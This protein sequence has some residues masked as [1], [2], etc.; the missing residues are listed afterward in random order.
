MITIQPIAIVKNNRKEIEDDFWGNVTSEIMLD[1]AFS[2]QSLTGIEDFSHLYII[3][4]FHKADKNKINDKSRHPRNNKNY[5]KIGIFA[6]RG[7]NRPNHIGLSTVQLIK[8]SGR[9]LFVTG[10]DAIDGT[11]V[12]DIKPVITEFMPQ[13]PIRQPQWATELMKNYWQVQI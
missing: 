9:S 7:K 6:Q 2:E 1:P 4:Y 11:P 8:K 5:P 12:I 3:Y 13:Q 10:L